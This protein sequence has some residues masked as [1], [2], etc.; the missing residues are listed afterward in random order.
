[1]LFFEMVLFRMR[2]RNAKAQ[3]RNKIF[4]VLL[5]RFNCAFA[6]LL[7]PCVPSM[8]NKYFIL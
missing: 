8:V 5:L 4:T 2:K 6:F 3:R 1:M 7:N